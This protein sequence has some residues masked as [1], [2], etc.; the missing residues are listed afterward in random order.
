MSSGKAHDRSIWLTFP[1][2]LGLAYWYTMSIPLSLLTVLQ[3]VSAGLFFSPD[4][5]TASNPFNRWDYLKLYWEGYR[6]RRRHRGFSHNIITG[7]TERYLYWVL[8]QI[9]V[10][11]TFAIPSQSMSLLVYSLVSSWICFVGTALVHILMDGHKL[12]F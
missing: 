1:F 10:S 2:V 3:W 8:P 4:L 6:K 12:R 9:P 11:L 7:S 5:D